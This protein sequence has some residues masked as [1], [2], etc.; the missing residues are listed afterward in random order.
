MNTNNNNTFSVSTRLEACLSYTHNCSNYRFADRAL[1]HTLRRWVHFIAS[2]RT[3]GGQFG[4]LAPEVGAY[5]PPS[6]RTFVGAAKRRR[7]PRRAGARRVTV[8][9]GVAAQRRHGDAARRRLRARPPQHQGVGEPRR[10]RRRFRRA[11]RLR[12][13]RFGARKSDANA[14]L[15]ARGLRRRHRPGRVG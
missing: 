4:G 2:S 6:V 8:V 5:R 11:S 14:L 12:G 3:T 13:V 9:T 10:R 15:A 1:I 7:P